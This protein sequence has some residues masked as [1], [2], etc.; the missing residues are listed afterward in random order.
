MK[1]QEI[2]VNRNIDSRQ[3]ESDFSPAELNDVTDRL[4]QEAL[5]IPGA[6]RPLDRRLNGRALEPPPR[7]HRIWR[8]LSRFATLNHNLAAPS[9][10]G[11]TQEGP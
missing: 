10:D 7:P 11:G 5:R 4:H 3:H 6:A 9:S 1:L 2:V 8:A